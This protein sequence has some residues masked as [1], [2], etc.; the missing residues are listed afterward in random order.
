MLHEFS[1]IPLY[2][3]DQTKKI[4][5][6]DAAKKHREDEKKLEQVYQS[7]RKP[8]TADKE[9]YEATDNRRTILVPEKQKLHRECLVCPEEKLQSNLPRRQKYSCMFRDFFYSITAFLLHRIGDAKHILLVPFDK[10]L[11]LEF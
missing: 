5:I 4:R 11:K 9:K 3:T 10:T 8:C 2:K 7:G 1:D 6:K